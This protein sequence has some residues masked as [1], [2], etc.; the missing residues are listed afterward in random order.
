MKNSQSPTEIYNYLLPK[1]MMDY[2]SVSSVKEHKGELTLLLEEKNII[3][4]EYEGKQLVS[5][6]F[7]P[8]SILEDFPIREF[9]VYLEIRRRKWRNTESGTI[10]SRN[11]ELAAKGTSY[12]QEFAAFLKEVVGYLPGER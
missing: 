9:K 8:S 1:G 11:W 10:V 7:Y 4:I 3:P 6:G 2:F 5:K 12:T